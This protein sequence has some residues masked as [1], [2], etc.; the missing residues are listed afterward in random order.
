MKRFYSLSLL[1]LFAS[2]LLFSS[3]DKKED[4]E[5]QKPVIHTVNTFQSVRHAFGGE[6]S[7]AH[8]GTFNFPADPTKVEKIRMFIKLRCPDGGCNAWDVFANIKVWDNDSETWFEI[9]RYITPYGVDNVQRPQGFI[10]DVTDFKSLLAG[11]VSLRSFVETWGSDGWLV[12]VD[13][14]VTEGNPDYPYYAVQNVLDYAQHSLHG[15]PYG[16]EH[17][18]VLQKTIGIPANA[19]ETCLRTIITGW[20]HATPLDPGGRGCAEWCFRTHQVAINGEAMFDHDMGPMGCG[21]NAVQPQYGNWTPD[22]AGWCPGMEV[23]VRKDLFADPMNGQSFTFN[24]EFQEWENNFQSTADN[25]HAYYA[26]TTFVVVKSNEPIQKP[27][28]N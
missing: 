15:V 9:G 6:F 20:G 24:Y 10:V 13:F 22:R 26:L 5:D 27:S 3:C 28:V 12:T 8:E 1:I 18:F 2:P 17:D 4:D 16:E 23:P 14:E 11:E 19:V 21:Q 7:Q 25:P